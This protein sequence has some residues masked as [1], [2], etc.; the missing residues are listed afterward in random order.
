GRF[1]EISLTGPSLALGYLDPA[2]TAAAFH[3]GPEGRSYHTGDLAWL[4]P[5]GSLELVGRRDGQVKLWGHRVETGEVEARLRALPGVTDAA[6]VPV[7]DPAGQ[8]QLA[9]YFTGT[10]EP[11]DVRA[12]LYAVLPHYMVPRVLV[13]M[14]SLPYTRT[15]KI[16]RTELP[17]PDWHAPAPSAPP[18]TPTEQA[19]ADV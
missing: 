8:L 4:L 15:A 16:S 19:I 17:A 6:V 2:Q 10:A 5:D 11:A 9:G 1:G 18:R 13:P 14:A 7:T 3:E 12:E